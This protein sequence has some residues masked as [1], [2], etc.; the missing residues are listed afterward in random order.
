MKAQKFNRKTHQYEDYELPAGAKG[1]SNDM[2][3]IVPCAACGKDTRFGDGFSSLEIQSPFGLGYMVCEECYRQELES[4]RKGG[5]N[6][7]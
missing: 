3:A 2:D 7:L 5:N 6:D 4:K 1:Y